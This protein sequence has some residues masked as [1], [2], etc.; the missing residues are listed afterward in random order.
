MRKTTLANALIL[1][2]VVLPFASGQQVG[3]D[4]Y[5]PGPDAH[6]KQVYEN[7]LRMGLQVTLDREVY[8]RGEAIQITAAV[9]NPTNE[10]LEV[11]DPNKEAVLDFLHADDQRL[12]IFEHWVEMAPKPSSQWPVNWSGSTVTL[13]PGQRIERRSVDNG[14]LVSEQN[15]EKSDTFMLCYGYLGMLGRC[16][17]AVFKVE[18]PSIVQAASVKLEK[19]RLITDKITG[20]VIQEIPRYT[21]AMLLEAG[22]KR[23]VVLSRE[24]VNHSKLAA[25]PGQKLEI[26]TV[27]S[28]RPYDRIAEVGAAV[29]SVRLEAASQDNIIVHWQDEAGAPRSVLVDKDRTVFRKLQ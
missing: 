4:Y 25:E 13:A 18:Q 17:Q 16:G 5:N 27:E 6:G 21:Y 2:G 19:P 10:T 9:W 24:W 14:L 29:Q 15:L 11:F 7:T 1:M 8:L 12:G 28:V 20:A 22:G 26:G 23:Y 3:V